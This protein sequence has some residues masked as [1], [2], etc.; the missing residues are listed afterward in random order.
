MF[1]R[2][3]GLTLP[4]LFTSFF[5]IFREKLSLDVTFKGHSASVDQL[6]WHR[7]HPDLL[8]TASGD[9]TARIWDAR[10]QKCVTSVATP[11]ENINIA[12]APDGSAFAVGNKEDL[13]TFFDA[14]TYRKIS[15]EQFQL[16][17]RYKKEVRLCD[18][19]ENTWVSSVAD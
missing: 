15:E 5:H 9:K 13:V 8:A 17:V 19:T 11:G 18:T 3:V 12:W 16:E 7:T 2:Q 14:R 4:A 1:T 6:R 10:T